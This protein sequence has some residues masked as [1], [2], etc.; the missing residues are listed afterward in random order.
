MI[1][2]KKSYPTHK[3]AMSDA[4]GM[5]KKYKQKYGVYKCDHCGSFH[6]R[7]LNK[8]FLYK[9]KKDKYPLKVTD[10][11]YE[12]KEPTKTKKTKKFKTFQPKMKIAN[13][14]LISSEM[15]EKLKLLCV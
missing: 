5:S 12:K 15:A 9:L 2:D 4:V 3:A 11:H 7:T 8:T 1:C 14:K 6:I 10:I 13:T